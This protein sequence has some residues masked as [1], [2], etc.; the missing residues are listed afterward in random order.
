MGTHLTRFFSDRISDFSLMKPDAINAIRDINDHFQTCK[1]L[2]LSLEMKDPS[3][4][5]IEEVT[6]IGTP[7]IL[8]EQINTEN[9]AYEKMMIQWKKFRANQRKHLPSPTDGNKDDHKRQE[10]FDG[11][12]EGANHQ[13][14]EEEKPRLRNTLKQCPA[15]ALHNQKLKRK[16]DEEFRRMKIQQEKAKTKEQR[17]HEEEAAAHINMNEIRR[18]AKTQKRAAPSAKVSITH[19]GRVSKNARIYERNR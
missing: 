16:M 10:H 1:E 13:T 18:K 7:K 4:N 19:L 5:F 12:G 6:P 11:E 3:I 8:R 17:Q 15:V 2:N 14:P 9:E